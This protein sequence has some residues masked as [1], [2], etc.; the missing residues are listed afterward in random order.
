MMEFAVSKLAFRSTLIGTAAL[1]AKFFGTI[2]I[3]GGT[4]IKT[5]GRPPED[6]GLFP[7][8]KK[9]LPKQTFGTDRGTASERAVM[10]EIRWTNIVR[11]DLETLPFGMIISWGTM[12]CHSSPPLHA[13]LVALFV[14]SRLF[15]T[16]SYA[17]EK[18][19][20]RSI[21]WFLGHLAIIGMLGNGLAGLSK[22]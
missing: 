18:Q 13:G 10:K 16:I 19:P 2:F 1:Y 5:G 20:A 17:Y 9:K 6:T 12:L 8:P 7:D 22:L 4:K 14:F 11:N 21:F 3:Q 15:Y